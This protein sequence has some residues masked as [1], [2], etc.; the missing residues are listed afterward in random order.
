MV[1]PVEYLFYIIN[2]SLA[3]KKVKIKKVESVGG[4]EVKGTHD[5]HPRGRIGDV[6]MKQTPHGFLVSAPDDDDECPARNRA[7]DVRGG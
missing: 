1:K 5:T 4:G 6:T 2:C 7:R 3:Q